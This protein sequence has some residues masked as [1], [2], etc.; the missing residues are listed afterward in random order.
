MDEAFLPLHRMLQAMTADGDIR[1]ER[2]GIHMYVHRY[3]IESPVELDVARGE[4]GSLSIGSVPPLYRVET[5][6]RP[7]YHQI[8]FAA[9]LSETVDHDA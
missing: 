6:F 4:D 8:R 3:S 5:S 2:H 1:S 7:S 9:E